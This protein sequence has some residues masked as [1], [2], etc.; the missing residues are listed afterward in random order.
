M[1]LRYPRLYSSVSAERL[2]S[3]P[4]P[5]SLSFVVRCGRC[6]GALFRA[7]DVLPTAQRQETDD[8]RWRSSCVPSS[9]RTR[10][11]ELLRAPNDREHL[12]SYVAPIPS[13]PARCRRRRRPR[14]RRASGFVVPSPIRIG[15][16]P[17]AISASM[18]AAAI[19]IDAVVE[20]EV[21]AVV[22]SPGSSACGPRRSRA[23]PR[24]PRPAGT[25]PPTRATGSADWRSG[26]ASRLRYDLN[27]RSVNY[28]FGASGT[29]VKPRAFLPSSTISA[30]RRTSAS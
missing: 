18:L 16:S 30:A 28:D 9:R 6:N 27:T 13:A 2:G 12:R 11:A 26:A 20:A 14:E 22:A 5:M 24:A 7:V 29:S 4:K 1:P 3:A 17:V 15:V 25:P 21:G 8:R 19:R 23:P 10:Y